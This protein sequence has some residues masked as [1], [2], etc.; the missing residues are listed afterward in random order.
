MYPNAQ[1][2]SGFPVIGT[3]A[4]CIPFFPLLA[5]FQQLNPPVSEYEQ[6]AFERRAKASVGRWVSLGL[7]IIILV[8]V[9][10]ATR[11]LLAAPTLVL[12]WLFTVNRWT[13]AN[14]GASSPRAALEHSHL[15][16]W[17]LTFA[18]TATW[19]ALA[20]MLFPA[21]FWGVISGAATVIA[22]VLALGGAVPTAKAV[23]RSQEP[24]PFDEVSHRLVAGVV[25]MTPSAYE[26]GLADGTFMVQRDVLGRLIARIPAGSDALLENLAELE[27]RV[28]VKAP[29]FMIAHA[30]PVDDTLIL[31]P[32]DDETRA[33]RDAKSRSGGLFAEHIGGGLDDLKVIDLSQGLGDQPLPRLG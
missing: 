27:E 12:A 8:G 22:T 10:F 5:D 15:V 3:L 7:T 32:V 18:L 13:W 17:T 26:R 29:E 24:P 19:A 1:R 4:N 20:G 21:G 23:L 6:V 16:W 25:K 14:G 9:A 11:G 33:Q 28:R 30:D 31:E 2:D